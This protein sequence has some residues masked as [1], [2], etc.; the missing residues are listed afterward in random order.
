MVLVVALLLMAARL[1]WPVRPD[2]GR[3]LAGLWP[4]PV[5]TAGRAGRPAGWRWTSSSSWPGRRARPGSSRR[6]RAAAERELVP[7]L[8]GL[9]STLR[10]GLTPEAAL[11][12]LARVGVVDLA[13]AGQLG[14]LVDTLAT[15]AARGERLEPTWRAAATRLASPSLLAVAEG[16]RLAER[17]GAPIVEV[18]DALVIALRDQARTD[19]AVA[20]A[21]AA[22]RATARLLG[23]LPL[24]G[25]AL[26]EL[27]GIHP[28]AVLV[29]TPVGRVAGLLGLAATLLGRAWMSR[30]IRAA[31]P[32]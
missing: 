2:P 29:G 32:R 12:H 26:G 16:W 4:V 1:V 17:H 18:L 21:M 5:E 19:A 14:S 22:P 8:D 10:A 13:G 25:V 20:T 28:V 30:L 6:A 27:V 31:G 7:L 3:R 9:A 11:G 15:R 24:G 23:V